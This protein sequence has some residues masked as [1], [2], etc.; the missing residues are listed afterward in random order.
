MYF[1]YDE[2]TRFPLCSLNIQ[3]NLASREQLLGKIKSQPHQTSILIVAL[4][5]KDFL[6][7]F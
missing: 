4:Y 1:V 5:L 2:E 7:V 3:D 6:I